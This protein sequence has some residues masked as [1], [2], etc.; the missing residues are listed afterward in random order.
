MEA[1]PPPL[2]DVERVHLRRA[3]LVDASAERVS[4]DADRQ[5]NN[6]DGFYFEFAGSRSAARPTAVGVSRSHG[7]ALLVRLSLC[8]LQCDKE[9]DKLRQTPPN[10][11]K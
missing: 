2:S 9:R 10:G 6:R 11:E 5:K 1:A 4:K 8:P 3:I 7:R